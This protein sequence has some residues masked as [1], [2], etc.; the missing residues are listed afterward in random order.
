M[1]KYSIYLLSL[2]AVFNSL[3]VQAQ[4]FGLT[5]YIKEFWLKADNP[6]GNNT[7]YD[8]D[9]NISPGTTWTD[10]SG[11]SNRSFT[12]AS[13]GTDNKVKFIYNGFNFHPAFLW[14]PTANSD[15]VRLA[16]ASAFTQNVS[17]S[18]YVF[19]VSKPS[20]HNSYERTLFSLH[21]DNDLTPVRSSI[22]WGIGPNE[23]TTNPLVRIGYRYNTTNNGVNYNFTPAQGNKPY[24]I[25]GL[26]LPND[27][28]TTVY[29][30][31]RSLTAYNTYY[32][33]STTAATP[34]IGNLGD[35]FYPYS[36]T[37]QEILM[38]S[39]PGNA[40][41]P[42]ADIKKIQSYLAVKYGITLLLQSAS[43]NYVNS[44]NASV[45]NYDSNYNSSI[46]GLGRD[47]AS[48]LYQKQSQSAD[49]SALKIFVG[50]QLKDLNYENRS[51]IPNGQYLMIGSNGQTGFPSIQIPKNT[52]YANGK[53][54]TDLTFQSAV[55]YKAQVTGTNNFTVKLQASS[56]YSY[57]LVSTSDQFL[58]ATTRLYPVNVLGIATVSLDNTYRYFRFA[59]YNAGPG[60]VDSGLKLWLRADDSNMITIENVDKTDATVGS[61]PTTEADLHPGSSLPAVVQWSDYLRNK[62][63]TFTNAAGGNGGSTRKPIYKASSPEMNFHPAVRFYSSG[64]SG[65][66]LRCNTGLLP[67]PNSAKHTAILVT[68]NDFS[69]NSWVYPMGF[70][71]QT[72]DYNGPQYGVE[73]SGGKIIGRLRLNSRGIFQDVV[74]GTQDLFKIGATSILHYDLNHD[75]NA[76]QG[77][78]T[79]RFNGKEDQ[80]SYGPFTGTNDGLQ[81][82]FNMNTYSILGGGYMADRV[83]NGV[84]AEV[85]IFEGNLNDANRAKINSYLAFK[86]GITIRTNVG[87]GRYD[88]VINNGQTMVWNGTQTTGKFVTYYNNV[89]AIVRDDASQLNNHQSH[90]TDQ[91]SILHLGVAGTQLGG[92]PHDID[93]LQDG[94][95]V[96]FGH[97]NASGID[98]AD[99][100]CGNFTK[101]F[102]RHWFIHK[103]TNDDRPVSVLVG[104]EDNSKNNLGKDATNADKEY[105]T[106]LGNPK[107][108]FFL[109]V[110]SDPAELND[111]Q[112]GKFKVVPMHY[113]NGE[114]Q[115]TYTFTEKDTYITFAYAP[116]V[117]GG[118]CVA[119]IDFEDR[120]TFKWLSTSQQWEYPV[121]TK[122]GAAS[123]GQ[124]FTKPAVNLGD[125]ISVV[126]SVA[127]D[128]DVQAPYGF[129][130]TVF[131]PKDALEIRRTHGT[132]DVSKVTVTINFQTTNKGIPEPVIPVFSISDLD[133]QG[134]NQRDEVI[135]TG[136]CGG[137]EIHPILTP[138]GTQPSFSISGNTARVNKNLSKD[139]T[140]KNGTV[141]VAFQS[142]VTQ[143]TI[144]YKLTHAANAQIQN[145]VISPIS[146]TP[147][148]KPVLLPPL[149]N[150]DGISFH[151]QAREKTFTA[152]E[153]VEFLFLIQNTNREDKYVK[154]Q[155][156]LPAGMTW[157][158]RSLGLDE[159]NIYSNDKLK[160][161]NY[162]NNT[163]LTVDSILV[164]CAGSIK[165]SATALIYEFT[166]TG[167]Y[168]NRASLSYEY[169]K[170]NGI[171][172][173]SAGDTTVY[174]TD[175][176][177]HEENT[178]VNITAATRTQPVTV[179][180]VES[181][182]TD[183]SANHEITILLEVHNPNTDVADLYTNINWGSNFNYV[184]GSL[185]LTSAS[186]IIFADVQPNPPYAAGD[187]IQS[188]LIAGNAN[189]DKGFILP[190]G[191]TVI[192][193]K[194]KA[195]DYEH[196]N[197]VDNSQ[198]GVH[199]LIVLW[200]FF[201]DTPDACIQHVVNQLEGEIIVPYQLDLYIDKITDNIG[202]NT[203]GAY[204][205]NSSEPNGT[206]AHWG[207]NPQGTVTI[208]G[209]KHFLF[210]T[211]IVVKFGGIPASGVTAINH[212]TLTCIPPTA[213]AST[214]WNDKTVTH[215]YSPIWG[216]EGNVD[217][218]LEVQPSIT[219]TV[220]VE[221]AYTYRAPMTIT[222]ISPTH[223][224][225]QGGDTVIIDGYNFFLPDGSKPAT[226]K[227]NFAA[228]GIDPA[229]AA[230]TVDENTATNSRI[231]VINAPHKVNHTHVTVDNSWEKTPYDSFTY[232][233]TVFIQN[234]K[235][236]E[237]AKWEDHSNENILP[238]PQSVIH[239]Q[240]NCVQ[241]ISV[242]MD[243]ITVY[244]SK[245]YTIDNEK[246]LKANVFTLLDNAS[247]LNYGTDNI[248]KAR[249]MHTLDK[250]RNW[251]IS[252]PMQ[253]G[254]I[255]TIENA[256]GK[257]K[258]GNALSN[259]RVE[260][261]DE[262]VH[263]W[264][265][266]SGAFTNSMGYTA[267]A[268][269]DA[270][271]VE[272]TGKFTDGNKTSPA[273]TRQNDAHPKR[274]F[275]LVGNPF[276]SF[277]RWTSTSAQAANLYSTI[278]YRTNVDGTTEGY[279]FW[280]YNAAG[281][282]AVAPGWEDEV[283]GAPY[284]LAYIPPMQ[285]FWVRIRDGHSGGTLTFNNERRSHADQ[286]NNIL[287]VAT[288]PETRPLIRLAVNGNG[289]AADETLIY[290]DAAATNGFD[291]YDSDKWFTNQGAEIFTLLL[292]SGDKLSI[293][294]LHH[295]T[296]GTEIPLGFQSQE[297]GIFSFQATEILNCDTL[298]VILRDKWLKKE[299]DLR[300]P[301]NYS[302]TSGH[303]TTTERFSIVF[304]P[305][306]TTDLQ[307][308][309]THDRFL[310]Y[311]DQAGQ[312]II[313]LHTSSLSNSTV[314]VSVF[315]VAGRQLTEQP[316][317]LG[318]R[319]TLKGVF[320]KGVY[321][322]RADKWSAKVMVD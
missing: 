78:V 87:T 258:Q 277:W 124:N 111:Y 48:G 287:K 274:G 266:A 127:Y 120:K 96:A 267:Y 317:T 321:L 171:Q 86:Y 201:I 150:E 309:G 242:D 264:Q 270:I 114:Q 84:M 92:H 54:N 158:P 181:S 183:Y 41:M 19:I 71:A 1:R 197:F 125:N 53:L 77:V 259:W 257:D 244:P 254:V 113:I 42:V 34:Y 89:A 75:I 246:T 72:G 217:V 36:G 235:W 204:T 122:A 247:F 253:N 68:N 216:Y 14:N 156:V 238:Y 226:I 224:T 186:P 175:Y 170:T 268:G 61:F 12:R 228:P 5:G 79:F 155:D 22:S 233:P 119:T 160:I 27:G 218:E 144:V 231:T 153:E 65:S 74:T 73:K 17:Q 240:A 308:A 140:D 214:I 142:G 278:W 300:S 177:T 272:F 203:G 280:A 136:Y 221:N 76:K 110:A 90:S 2:L 296:A 251:Y 307:G 169:F 50:N 243:S 137:T 316:I 70:G 283:H 66:Y 286:N 190:S 82:S 282:V 60:G 9:Q 37:I 269:D 115:C 16:C 306:S 69:S 260:R 237:F 39:K 62:D 145:I 93:E 44:S 43:D 31:G 117:S 33:W 112:N 223:G 265:A 189:G 305:S 7:L 174:S 312:I 322:L 202:P 148:E 81:T 284:S 108:R 248:V 293:N 139:A 222:G 40:A 209:G 95:A 109:L 15:N 116:G 55:I 192:Q 35:T 20:R 10:L 157:K 64:Y 28:N 91:G 196:L 135:V 239:I 105:Y 230:A 256:L 275:N 83:I 205:H 130:H 302:F 152:C 123:A 106:Q 225:T 291:D 198:T 141:N 154:L 98:H 252:S 193:F 279:Q 52:P 143:I 8:N 185:T 63:Y 304:R 299:F 159:L 290:A 194:V 167:N 107:N 180:R 25:I 30:N 318:E 166:A 210:A 57:A 38:L 99:I 161:S 285:A 289:K 172:T 6:K 232:F 149:I 132:V 208:I 24:G 313:E 184:P 97:D 162:G 178:I 151:K 121:H 13:G 176:E 245:S 288:A 138:A 80:V 102:K 303:A 26:N 261:Y 229:P 195:P 215:T 58:P 32:R 262:P 250:G 292:A 276:P 103:V 46:F 297:G 49:N 147:G 29:L 220:T 18:Y 4:D 100:L 168:P 187:T 133:A 319:T 164:K 51:T 146:F 88:Y 126:A 255:P 241:D 59:G 263:Q 191:N 295:I 23:N 129:P 310:A 271:A 298:K 179:V 301:D 67:Y 56:G 281:R 165:V 314:M 273:L 45:W 249:A 11:Q 219:G 236:T 206:P 234:G 320:N 199:P 128:A 212:H 207:I 315:D 211:S 3:T 101:V 294:G 47:D 85:I 21:P 200:D 227:V 182:P 131:V 213:I 163:T 188:L 173:V 134:L 104:A 311:T 118:G 94:E